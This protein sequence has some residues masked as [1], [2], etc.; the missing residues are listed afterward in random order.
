[1]RNVNS[2]KPDGKMLPVRRHCVS[3]YYTGTHTGSWSWSMSSVSSTTKFLM[4]SFQPGRSGASLPQV[5]TPNTRHHQG[6]TANPVLDHHMQTSLCPV[7]LP[8]C[9]VERLFI[10]LTPFSEIV[11][12]L[13]TQPNPHL[14]RSFSSC[15]CPWKLS[16]KQK[17]GERG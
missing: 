3:G 15:S 14:C 4:S 11:Y 17:D 1:M 12:I 7:L 16:L 2:D 9:S 8:L 10:F 6:S 13:S 5:P